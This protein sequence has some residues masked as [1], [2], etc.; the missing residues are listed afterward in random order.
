MLSKKFLSDGD[1]PESAAS[2]T[3]GIT[4]EAASA[5]AVNPVTAFSFKEA[6]TSNFP[7][8]LDDA[9]AIDF[10]GRTGNGL[11]KASDPCSL[12]WVALVMGMG[13]AIETA[14]VEAIV[15]CLLVISSLTPNCF[16]CMRK[17]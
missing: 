11:K 1:N 6:L 9:A 7:L 13:M 3:S 4:I 14:K 16:F 2:A 12:F 8:D 5:A 17:F 15:V 10:E